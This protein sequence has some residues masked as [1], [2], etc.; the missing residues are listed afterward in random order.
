MKFVGVSAARN[1]ND[2]VGIVVFI[3]IR[4]LRVARFPGSSVIFRISGAAGNARV[5]SVNVILIVRF[6]TVWI[7]LF[8]ATNAVLE[9]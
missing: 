2:G 3:R 8:T 4:A 5:L 9:P 6:R 1:A 7:A